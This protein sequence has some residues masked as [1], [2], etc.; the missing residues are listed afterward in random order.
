MAN[1]SLTPVPVS[2]IFAQPAENTKGFLKVVQNTSM[3]VYY[4]IVVIPVVIIIIGN[5]LSSQT[6][7]VLGSLVSMFVTITFV[8]AAPAPLWAAAIAYGPSRDAATSILSKVVLQLLYWQSVVGMV[9]MILP[10]HLMPFGGLILL[11]FTIM[12]LA[13]GTPLRPGGGSFGFFIEGFYMVAEMTFTALVVSLLLPDGLE[14]AVTE[15]FFT[16]LLSLL[17]FAGQ[18]F[19]GYPGIELGRFF[20][21][22]VVLGLVVG[23]VD[24]FRRKVMMR[25]GKAAPQTARASSS[26]SSASPSSFWQNFPWASLLSLIAGSVGVYM[27]DSAGAMR[28]T[29]YPVLPLLLIPAVLFVSVRN[30]LVKTLAVLAMVFFIVAGTKL[31]NYL[32][33]PWAG[34]VQN[35]A[36]VVVDA[37]ETGIEKSAEVGGAAINAI[38]TPQAAAASPTAGTLIEETVDLDRAAKEQVYRGKKMDPFAELVPTRHEV[39]DGS[40]ITYVSGDDSLYVAKVT[41]ASGKPLILKGGYVG[42]GNDFIFKGIPGKLYLLGAGTVKI[43]IE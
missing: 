25:M 28:L 3:T 30:R 27:Y 16:Q 39:Q 38:T 18:G 26:S 12:V 7:V 42:K 43:R 13:F 24:L 17:V 33:G 31:I 19:V 15:G 23:G 37:A 20:G 34:R 5:L 29:S 21:G 4:F 6:I 10:V 2:S 1:T 40:K 14:K 41:E 32:P 35:A 11:I 36:Q 8:L 9:A 22:L